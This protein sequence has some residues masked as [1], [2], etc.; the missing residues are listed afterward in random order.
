MRTGTRSRER[1]R[2]PVRIDIL[3]SHRYLIFNTKQ[4]KKEIK[5]KKNKIQVMLYKLLLLLFKD[6]VKK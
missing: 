6:F 5:N 3:L 2:A 4:N 1:E